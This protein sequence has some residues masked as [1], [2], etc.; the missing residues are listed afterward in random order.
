MKIAEYLAPTERLT[1]S[2]EGFSAFETA[3]RRIGPLYNQEAQDIKEEGRL[4]AQEIEDLS[5]WP[6]DILNLRND[7][8]EAQAA[9]AAKEGVRIGSVTEGYNAVSGNAGQAGRGGITDP[10]SGDYYSPFDQ[11]SRGAPVMAATAR[12]LISPQ[13][14]NQPQSS[15]FDPNTVT[16]GPAYTLQNGQFVKVN[17]QDPNAGYA[18]ANNQLIDSYSQWYD[19]QIQQNQDLQAQA[20]ASMN[21]ADLPYLPSTVPAS[22]QIPNPAYDPTNPSPDVPKTI[23]NPNYGQPGSFQDPTQAPTGTG[24]QSTWNPSADQPI[25]NPP[26]PSGSP[27]FQQILQGENP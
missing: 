12:Q 24:L 6:F 13:S 14:F 4:K 9:K 11:I 18:Q 3:G 15:T 27:N 19:Q 23:I 10:S 17:N 22:Q 5:R 8:A 25:T 20:N 1:P 26:A 7:V 21:P 2:N 16:T